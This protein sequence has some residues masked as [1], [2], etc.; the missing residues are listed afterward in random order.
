[1]QTKVEVEG[2]RDLRRRLRQVDRAAPREL[3]AASKA[4]AAEVADL[5]A[6]YAPRVT[7]RLAESIKVGSR[8]DRI[9]VRSPLPYA[10]PIHWGWP[11]RGIRGSFFV[12][13]AAAE[14]RSEYIDDLHEVIRDVARRYGL[15]PDD[16]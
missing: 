7:G 3:N 15:G 10:A 9:T 4:I 2:L 14:R 8:G 5:A 13:R 1:M 16:F 6:S 12:T 11:T